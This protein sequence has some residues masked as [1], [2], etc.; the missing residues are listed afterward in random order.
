MVTPERVE[1]QFKQWNCTILKRKYGNGRPAVQLMDAEDGSPVATA[2][3]NLPDVKLQENEVIIK[4]YSE[5]EGMY[6]ALTSAGIIS[7]QKRA[8]ASGFII[9][10]VCDL[11]I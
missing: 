7:E 8:V 5:N 10:P 9:A 1:I 6:N 4:D 2:T 3:I 11:L